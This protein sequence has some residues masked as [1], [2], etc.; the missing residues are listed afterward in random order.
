MLFDMNQPHDTLLTRQNHVILWQC[1]T[2]EYCCYTQIKGLEIDFIYLFLVTKQKRNYSIT[3]VEIKSFMDGWTGECF[4]SHLH[5]QQ[6]WE[7]TEE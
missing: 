2:K 4:L 7:S 1:K 6:A 5:K 3:H